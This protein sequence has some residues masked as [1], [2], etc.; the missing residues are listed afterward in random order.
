MSGSIHKLFAKISPLFRRKRMASF[1]AAFKPDGR[2][3]V[4]DLGGLPETWMG[5]PG[6]FPV[7]LVNLEPHDT[8]NPRF[9]TVKCDAACLPFPDYS[10][11]IVF[12]NSLIEHLGGFEKQQ[13]FAREASRL[14]R[15][16]WIQTPARWFPIEPHL[17]APFVHYFPK[18]LQKRLIRWFTVWGWLAKPTPQQVAEFL[19]EVNL[20]TYDKMKMLFPDCEILKERL[21][22]F[23]KSYI[24]FRI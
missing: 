12:S 22:G 9:T 17:I 15:K 7:V 2:T 13:V 18:N 11:D 10:F 8:Q 23:T 14:A 21:L 6:D 5:S 3:K 19:A 4:I 20:L 1:F 24:A 16:L